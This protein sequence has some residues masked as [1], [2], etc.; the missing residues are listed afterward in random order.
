[1]ITPFRFVSRKFL[2]FASVFLLVAI[3]TSSTR[4]ATATATATSTISKSVAVPLPKTK[5]QSKKYVQVSSLSNCSSSSSSEDFAF[6]AKRKQQT[7]SLKAVYDWYLESCIRKPFL[8]KG[9]TAGTIAALGDVIA[10]NIEGS[11]SFSAIR[12]ATFFFCNLLFTGPFLH[13]WYT[14][15]NDVGDWMDTRFV[16]ISKLK[17]TVA[18]V[19]LDQTLGISVFFPLYICI[20]DMFDS[21]IRLHRLPS[22]S[23]ATEKCQKH[24]R[25]IIL[26]Q[27]RVFPIANMINFGLIPSELRVLFTSTVSIFWNIYLCSVVG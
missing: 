23:Q 8:A 9:I 14:F 6:V 20:Y 10:Q 18:Q 11:R 16:E 13:L 26:T 21:V 4:A 3:T 2:P 7:P 17:K 1:M 25:S 19:V 22:W 27:F 24:V 15:L 12:V 5:T